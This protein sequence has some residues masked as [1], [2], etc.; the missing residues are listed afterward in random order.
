MARRR[1]TYRPHT[2]PTFKVRWLD[3]AAAVAAIVMFA[4]LFVLL[5]DTHTRAWG[6][7]EP[8]PAPTVTVTQPSAEPVDAKPL[9]VGAA[10]PT[11]EPDATA[12]PVTEPE[13]EP[14]STAEPE[15]ELP[16]GVTVT[17]PTWESADLLASGGVP[18]WGT[19]NGDVACWLE[20]ATGAEVQP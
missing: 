16:V 1:Q 17:F 11:P 19:L 13:P 12:E 15:P 7:A 5:L 2:P 3:V 4:A 14:S 9:Q 10:T 18:C 8:D 20:G 6:A